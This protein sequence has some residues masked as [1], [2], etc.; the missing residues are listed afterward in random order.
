MM[1]SGLKGLINCTSNASH[2][3]HRTRAVFA[4]I[5]H[6]KEQCKSYRLSANETNVMFLL[7]NF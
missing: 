3:V 4:L 1:N 7:L 6:A 2:L 5:S